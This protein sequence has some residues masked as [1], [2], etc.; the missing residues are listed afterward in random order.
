MTI[1]R[2]KPVLLDEVITALNPRAGAI[3]I[4]GTFGG[5]GYSRALLEAAPCQVWGIDRD[6][7]ACARGDSLSK[8]FEGRLTV[9]CGCFGDM[10][11]LLADRGVNAVDGI[12]LDLG[13]SSFQIDE[14]ERGFSFRNDGPLDMR[15]SHDGPSAAYVVNGAAEK[16]LADI[17]Y[18][19]GEE[20]RSR[21]IARAIVAARRENPITRTEQLATIVRSCYPAPRKAA[22]DT[23]DPATRTFQALRIYVNN[24]LGELARGLDAAEALLADGGRLAVV[25]FHS[26]EDRI[27]KTFLRDR[28]GRTPNASR[29]APDQPTD[30]PASTFDLLARRA[31]KPGETE[32]A[33]N[34]RARS[35]RLRTAER[36]AAP[37]WP[38][39]P[40]THGFPHVGG[41]P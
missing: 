6:P 34:P 8:E 21:R 41:A 28:A 38:A 10:G 27:V 24:E 4:D 30:G 36:T 7:D 15:M 13:V 14:A 32:I 11:S 9:L 22:A 39:R 17:I 31:I 19:Y 23:I 35:A 20:R 2:H 25:S 33:S 16:A 37:P 3:Y 12:T 29:H 26:L 40:D 18:L 1:G 5:G